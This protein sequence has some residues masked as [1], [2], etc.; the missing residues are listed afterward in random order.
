MMRR[1]LQKYT[2]TTVNKSSHSLLGLGENDLRSLMKDTRLSVLGM[3][4]AKSGLAAAELGSKAGELK[5]LL[6]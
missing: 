5:A 2:L 1:Q 3:Y 4:F 6:G